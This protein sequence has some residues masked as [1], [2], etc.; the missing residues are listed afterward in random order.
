[1]LDALLDYI[2]TGMVKKNLHEFAQ[3]LLIVAHMYE[4]PLLVQL[5]ELAMIE[6]IQVEN[7]TEYLCL[8][9]LYNLN[10][11]KNH[12]ITYINAHSAAVVDT[13]E[14][15]QLIVPRGAL[16]NEVFKERLKREAQKASLNLTT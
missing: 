1:M 5:C 8:A 14:W 6:T 12:A 15:D 9:D 7:A 3:Y 4:I 10:R 13:P 2:Y 11:L 16:L